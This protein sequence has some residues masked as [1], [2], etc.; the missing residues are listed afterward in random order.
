MSVCL[1]DDSSAFASPA[2]PNPKFRIAFPGVSARQWLLLAVLICLAI[3]AVFLLPQQSPPE[4]LTIQKSP[5]RIQMTTSGSLE[6]LRTERVQSKCQWTVQILSLVPEGTWVRKGDIVCVLD[7]SKIEEFQRS[8][9]VTLI[10]A[11]VKLQASKQQEELLKASNERRLGEAERELQAAELDLLEY[12]QGIH[13]NEVQQLA[14]DI[15]FNQDR[16]QNADGTLRFSERLWMLGYAN[17]AE[18]DSQS[19]ALTTQTEQV[20]RLEFKRDLLQDFTH[21]RRDLQMTHHLNNSQLQIHRTEL[22]N[23]LA[24]SKARL[25]TLLDQNRLSI[26]E[27]LASSA[28]ESI[29]ACNLRAPR[30]GQV[31]HCYNWKLRSRG[32]ITIE[33]GKS[34]YFS[35]P[36]FEIP[37][38]DHLKISLP[39]NESLITRVSVGAPILIRPVG[40]D[41]VAVPAAISRISPYPVMRDRFSD[42][43]EYFLDAILEPRDEQRD[44][45]RPRME[46][47]AVL[48]LM[49]KQDAITVPPTALIRHAGRNVVLMKS[50]DVLLPC[51]VEPGEV[52]DGKVLIESGLH[53]G[54]QIVSVVTD[55]QRRMLNEKLGASAEFGE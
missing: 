2:E 19:L 4:M 25:G 46:A 15:S 37:D 32:V 53:E 22:A 1:P 3:F 34:V 9:E 5:F 29:N 38:Q 12:S 54:D 41:D 52:S 43:K 26:Y 7:S 45:L 39:L 44:L 30:D 48:T 40:L 6:P 18:V 35:Q 8:R 14:D 33:E 17:R 28:Q 24:V 27:R 55:Q 36:I 13:P 51:Q 50:G 42:V 11:D 10:K 16:L 21:P 31:I 49:E 47:E 20:R 23:A